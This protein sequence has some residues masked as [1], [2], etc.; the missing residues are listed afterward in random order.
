[1]GWYLC[2]K[3]SP[4]RNLKWATREAPYE[5]GLN[6]IEGRGKGLSVLSN[7][8]IVVL[9]ETKN[10]FSW[11]GTPT[12][13]AGTN[14]HFLLMKI[15]SLGNLIWCRQNFFGG[16]QVCFGINTDVNNNI[17]LPYF[18]GGDQGKLSK[19]DSSGNLIWNIDIHNNAMNPSYFKVVADSS[20]NTYL[21][22]T[23]SHPGGNGDLIPILKKYD[24]LGNVRA[25]SYP[26]PYDYL[27]YSRPTTVAISPLGKIYCAGIYKNSQTLGT[28]TINSTTPKVF[29]DK[30]ETYNV[31]I[32]LNQPGD[33]SICIGGQ[34]NLSVVA[35]G[36]SLTYQWR[37]N[38]INLVNGGNIS[39]ANTS[40]LTINSSTSTDVALIHVV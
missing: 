28:T 22:Y 35:S 2:C 7:K 21:A 29:L 16:S 24:A 19:Y 40:T 34:V 10:Q 26:F 5:F 25:I 13:V 9:L 37:K 38:G 18:G 23:N 15:D 4:D 36:D 11:N 12:C 30:L 8:D 6:S 17:Y 20:G 39:G 3:Y 27:G 14:T 32:I 33:V 31:P 1:M